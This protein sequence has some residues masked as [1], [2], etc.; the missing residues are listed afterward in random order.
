MQTYGHHL[1]Q[2]I[3]SM[4]TLITALVGQRKTVGVIAAPLLTAGALGGWA[5]LPTFATTTATVEELYAFE[6]R[7][8]NGLPLEVRLGLIGSY[9]VTGTDTGG[10]PY[11]GAGVVDIVLAPS[12]ALELTWDYGK[13]VGIG[14][15]IG[16]ALAVASLSRGRT[17]ILLM[18][19]NQDGSLSGKSLR[20]TDRGSKGTET[21]KKT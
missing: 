2:R 21:W 10:E 14:Q 12:G 20:R 3:F 1:L 7:G 16:N 18:T 4:N 15:V 5:I 8:K 13:N 11:V 17:V 9:A 6:T 19:I